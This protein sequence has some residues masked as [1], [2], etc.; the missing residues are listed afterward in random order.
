[1]A[2]VDREGRETIAARLDRQ[3]DTPRFSPDGTRVAFR[4][5]APNCD[6]WVR[7]L[8]RGTSVRVTR[9]E[10]NHGAV[11]WPDGTRVLSARV[12]SG[13]TEI[14]A[15]PADGGGA[16]EVVA[17]MPGALG[18]IPT[19][20]AST[21]QSVLVQDRFSQR[22]GTDIVTIAA[23]GGEQKTLL[24]GPSEEGGGVVSPDGQFVA[25]VS[26]ESGRNEV[27]VRPYSGQGQRTLVSTSGGIEPV[28]SRTGEELF[29]RNGRDVLAVNMK[30]AAGAASLVPRVL[31]SG[32]YPIGPVVANYDVMPDGK[33]FLMMK[34][35]QW[36]EGQVV[37]VLNWFSQL[38]GTGK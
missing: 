30:S 17:T 24:N 36:P 1:M 34:G 6:I 2:L 21:S 16:P 8:A 19:S 35:S 13:G 27:Y 14:I 38:K 29:F 18:A 3:A 4:T 9:E 5:P 26:D 23:Q 31:F 12:G 11:W 37:V 32:D 7:D 33:R 22:T 15:L 20:W 10:D 25:Y 28:W